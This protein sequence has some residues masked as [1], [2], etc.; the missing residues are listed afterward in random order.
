[1]ETQIGNRRLKRIRLRQSTWSQRNGTAPQTQVIANHQNDPLM[2]W[3]QIAAPVPL[4]ASKKWL[5]FAADS[6][7][8]Q[9]Q[10]LAT[11]H[12]VLQGLIRAHTRGFA[13]RGC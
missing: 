3:Q 6:R 4:R 10:T 8:F 2:V 7:S 13:P 5:G 1:M 12:Q 9:L 11:R